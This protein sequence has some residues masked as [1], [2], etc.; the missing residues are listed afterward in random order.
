MGAMTIRELNANI[1]R[2]IARVE[3]G[4]TIDVVKN[5]KVVAEI[6]AKDRRTDPAWQAAYENTLKR[7]GKG[8]DLGIGKITEEDKY[9]DAAL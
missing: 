9:G 6:R 3:G 5:G 4:E 8:L 2:A 7:L 1:S